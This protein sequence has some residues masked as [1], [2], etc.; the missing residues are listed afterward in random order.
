[1][2]PSSFNGTNLVQQEPLGP[3]GLRCEA[4]RQQER[5]DFFRG[6]LPKFDQYLKPEHAWGE[7]EICSYLITKHFPLARRYYKET[8]IVRAL[9][10]LAAEV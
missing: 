1:M 9:E 5:T 3:H 6:N 8:R 4:S 2:A 10:F 7:Y